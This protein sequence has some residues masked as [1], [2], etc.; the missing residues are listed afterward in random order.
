[1]WVLCARE[2]EAAGMWLW[3]IAVVG[4]RQRGEGL[5]KAEEVRVGRG[6]VMG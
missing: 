5:Y 4:M 1:M 2:D 3:R 6:R